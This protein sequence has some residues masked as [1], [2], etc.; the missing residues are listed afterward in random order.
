MPK[1]QYA[2]DLHLELNANYKYLSKAKNK[3]IP[4]GDILV[5]AGDITLADQR[6][7]D[8][9]FFDWAASNFKTT[10]YIP[11]NHEFYNGTPADVLEE[12]FEIKVRDNVYFINNR[13]ITVNDLVIIFT[14][15][16]SSITSKNAEVIEES[17]NDFHQLWYHAHK[18]K[19][20]DF[21]RLHQ[22]CYTF[23]KNTLKANKRKKI[24]VVTHHV[25]S[26]LCCNEEHRNSPIND[27]F[28]A[29]LTDFIK[30]NTNIAY[31]IYGHS[32]HNALPKSIGK[33]TLIT[34]QLGYVDERE[35]YTFRKDAFIEID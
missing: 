15:L 33:T 10:Y 6:H 35:F 20:E 1:I 31:W 11:G 19:T 5:L 24:I 23:L 4:K 22:T 25:P 3:I 26:P 32:H 17:V 29:D 30:L 8:H 34:N 14:P 16:W 27:A 18:L 7:F 21:N 12:S 2:S 13:S 28:C 9:E